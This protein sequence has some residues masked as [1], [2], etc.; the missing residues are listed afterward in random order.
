MSAVIEAKSQTTSSRR[1]GKIPVRNLW[2]LMLYASDLYRHLGTNKVDVEENPEDIAD[3][4]A[5]I[6]CHQ[7]EER[8]MRNLSY[9]YESKVAVI[10]RVRGRIDTLTTER[11]R[12]LEKGK[13][14]CR[15]D[16]LTV[17]TPRNRYVRSA[18]ERLSKLNIKPTLAHK[19]RALMLSLERLGVSKAKPINYSGKSERFGRHDI[20]DQKMVAAADLAFSLALPTEFD[21]QFHL[22]APDSQ[23]EWLRKL[24]EKAIAGFYTVALNRKEWRVLAGKQFDWQISDKT[25]GIDEILPSMK[26]DIIIATKFN[27]VTTKGWH[28]EET[29]RSGYIYQMYT[30]LRSQ[31]DSSDPKSLVSLGMLLH[32][33]IGNEVTEMVKIQGHPIWFCTVNLGESAASIRER[34]LLLLRKSFQEK[35]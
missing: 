6:L 30:Y 26:T 25:S 17:D 9:G 15:F 27:S 7:V 35:N 21:G 23:K 20:S 34:L 18:L 13:V 28:R 16:E 22:T 32:P 1:L 33:T 8:M 24:F 4:V 3:L 2:L 10:S 14:C 11:Q 31:E 12:L 19:C 5:E 29:L